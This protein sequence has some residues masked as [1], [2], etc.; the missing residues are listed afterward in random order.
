MAV[1]RE[2]YHWVDELSKR[3]VQIF[4][5]A[6]DYGVPVRKG[7]EEWEVAKKL[8]EW[9]GVEGTREYNDYNVGKSVEH[10]IELMDEWA[11]SDGRKTIPEATERFQVGYVT[12]N[13]GKC[14]GKSG[15]IWIT[16]L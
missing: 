7:D 16:R 4:P 11:V 10:T 6:A 3:S 5:D 1:Y 12:C 2:G 15:Y 8:V 9:Y 14:K 13:G